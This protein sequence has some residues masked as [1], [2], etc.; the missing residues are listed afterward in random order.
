VEFD[1]QYCF[2]GNAKLSGYACKRKEY[3]HLCLLLNTGS[4]RNLSQRNTV[5]SR[6]ELIILPPQYPMR[7][8]IRFENNKIQCGYH[9]N[10]RFAIFSG[11]SAI[12]IT[13]ALIPR[14]KQSCFG[15]IFLRN[16]DMYNRYNSYDWFRPL[17]HEGLVRRSSSQRDECVTRLVA[18]PSK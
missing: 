8:N 13:F 6:Y 18:I 1:T 3:F 15:L 14:K 7:E 9:E 12:S 5:T 11:D 16:K 10:E 17:F 2:C 4:S